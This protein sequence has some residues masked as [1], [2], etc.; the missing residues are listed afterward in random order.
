MKTKTT[1]DTIKSILRFIGVSLA[2]GVTCFV[3]ML[4]LIKQEEFFAIIFNE[5]VVGFL[6]IVA[7]TVIGFIG[8]AIYAYIKTSKEVT[9]K[10]H[11]ISEKDKENAK[12]QHQLDEAE[13]I[14]RNVLRSHSDMR[15]SA[16]SHR[17]ND[18]FKQIADLSDKE[19]PEEHEEHENPLQEEPASA[20]S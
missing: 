13:Q 4:M 20:D 8:G 6:G 5:T 18:M 16:N 3:F 12:L 2:T 7:G 15:K 14:V 17:V 1:T 19:A 9:E 10:E 11:I